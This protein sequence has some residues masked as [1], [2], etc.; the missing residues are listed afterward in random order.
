MSWG[1]VT[2]EL[3]DGETLLDDTI[4]DGVSGDYTL[5]APGSGN[6]TVKASKAGF[7][8]KTQQVTVGTDPVTLDFV[9]EM[10]LIPSAC[11]MSYVLTCVNHWLYP[12]G[13]CGLTMSTVLA[14]VN[15]WL[16]PQ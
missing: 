1:A 2:L 10:G 3:F 12:V 7:R 15:A 9:G 8:D 11:N 14:V 5:T 6:Y 4:S 13:D 16:Y